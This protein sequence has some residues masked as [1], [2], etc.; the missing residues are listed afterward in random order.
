MRQKEKYFITLT[1][2]VE[3]W[4]EMELITLSE[5][6]AEVLLYV[7]ATVFNLE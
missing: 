7:T 3:I 4:E 2:M 5:A 1:N 6:G